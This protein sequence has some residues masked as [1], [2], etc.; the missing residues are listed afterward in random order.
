MRKPTGYDPV[1]SGSLGVCSLSPRLKLHVHLINE[2]E[3]RDLL[4]VVIPGGQ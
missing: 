2:C 4:W 3:M 1:L